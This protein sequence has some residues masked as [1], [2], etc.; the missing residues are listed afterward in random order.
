MTRINIGISPKELT[1]KHLLAEHREITRLPMMTA[2]NMFKS[3]ATETFCLGKGHVLFFTNKGK[4]TFE[5]YLELYAECI[6][7]GF[8]VQNYSNAWDVYKSKPELFQ[9]YIPSIQDIN[10]ISQRLNE[11]LGYEKFQIK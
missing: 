11:K 1:N 3:K 2:K 5:R 6:E 9:D 8:N 7:R 4:Y 10:I